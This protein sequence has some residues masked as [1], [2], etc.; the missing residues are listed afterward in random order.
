M[1]DVVVET[2]AAETPIVLHVETE[3]QQAREE[4]EIATITSEVA[5]AKAI[6]TEELVE[7]VVE[8]IEEI[9][10]EQQS[11]RGIRADMAEMRLS[12]AAIQASLVATMSLVSECLLSIRQPVMLPQPEVVEEAQPPVIAVPEPQIEEKEQEKPKAEPKPAPKPTPKKRNRL[13]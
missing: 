6:E 3:A 11:W 10:E 4:A 8:V 1:D 7:E 9:K 2:V 13:I 12:I 5:V